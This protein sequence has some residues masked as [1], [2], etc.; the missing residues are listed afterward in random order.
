MSNEEEVISTFGGTV[1]S[2]CRHNSADV[3]RSFAVLVQDLESD[4]SWQI[5][6]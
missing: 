2:Q 6:G 3:K 1:A 5:T 4:Y